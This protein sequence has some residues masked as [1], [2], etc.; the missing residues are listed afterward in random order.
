MQVVKSL[1]RGAEM[2]AVLEI[3]VEEKTLVTGEELLAM[4]DIG[5]CELIEGEIIKMSP[6]GESHGIVEINFATA[7]KQFVQPRKLGRVSGS[8]VGIFTRRSPD[9][10][11]GADVVFVSKAR[12]A[13]RG[14]SGYL[15][16]AP[17]L[18]VEILSPD[19]RMSEM[20][21]KLGEYFSIGVR[22]VWVADP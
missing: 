16:V 14:K 15:D 1:M 19:D 20:I 10:V 8:E 13:K 18:V 22:L 4:G 21:K 3:P 7:L 5:P 11:R 6:T 2:N 12:L 9:S 17:D